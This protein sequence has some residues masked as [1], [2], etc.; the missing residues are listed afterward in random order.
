MTIDVFQ[1]SASFP[2]SSFPL[3]LNNTILSHA[4]DAVCV[5]NLTGHGNVKTWFKRAAPKHSSTE[6]KNVTMAVTL[7]IPK[8]AVWPPYYYWT[9]V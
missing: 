8:A 9:P 2:I 1:V 5:Q 3:Q 4:G 7:D 6:G